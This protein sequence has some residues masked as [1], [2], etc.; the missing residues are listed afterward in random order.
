MCWKLSPKVG[1]GKTIPMSTTLMFVFLEGHLFYLSCLDGAKCLQRK[2]SFTC[3]DHTRVCYEQFSG[4][5]QASAMPFYI[6]LDTPVQQVLEQCQNH[7][8]LQRPFSNCREELCS[9]GAY[10]CSSRCWWWPF[11]NSS[12]CSNMPATYDCPKNSLHNP[13]RWRL[14][15]FSII[16][17]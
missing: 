17:F 3:V 7:G 14:T 4:F 9:L 15:T 16:L 1:K 2:A 11:P 5:P 13:K 10:L 12:H 6:K 8:C